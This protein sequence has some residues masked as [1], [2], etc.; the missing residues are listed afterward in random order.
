MNKVLSSFSITK[1]NYS[2]VKI[3]SF[4]L[5]LLFVITTR[6]IAQINYQLYN[7]FSKGPVGGGPGYE[8]MVQ[9]DNSFTRVNTLTELRT[10]LDNPS[11][12]KIFIPGN[13]YF[14]I[15]APIEITTDDL[16]IAS[17]RG[18]FYTTGRTSSGA[19]LKL[20]NASV[21]NNNLIF[22]VNA[23]N[24]RISGLRLTC[25]DVE[26]ISV[27]IQIR[28]K[29]G[30]EKMHLE[31][32][33]CELFNW[34]YAA[35]RIDGTLYT[36]DNLASGWV[37]H[38]HIHHNNRAGLGYGVVIN[39]KNVRSYILYNLF[40]ENR[41]SI[42]GNGRPNEMYTAAYNLTLKNSMNSEYDMHGYS[43]Y[44][45]K[46]C[47]ALADCDPYSSCN[48]AGARV[49]LLNNAVV[50]APYFFRIR[51]IPTE[52]A[53]VT[54]NFFNAPNSYMLWRTWSYTDELGSCELPVPNNKSIYLGKDQWSAYKL[55][56][57]DNNL[58]PHGRYIQYIS[59]SGRNSWQPLFFNAYQKGKIAFGD[60]NGDQVSDIFYSNGTSWQ[61]S[62]NGVTPWEK[63]NTSGY[64]K[65]QLAFGDFNGDS[66]TDVFTGNGSEWKVSWSG[67][68]GWERINTSGYKTHQLAFGDFNGDGTTDVFTG[69]GSEWKVS[70]SGTSGWERINTSGYKTHQLAFGDFNGDGITDVFAGKGSEWEVSWGG[71]SG[72]ERIN[73]T[74]YETHQLAFGDFNGDGTTDVFTGNGSE[75]KV[76]WS[77]TSSWERINTSIHKTGQLAFGDF[78]GDGVTDIIRESSF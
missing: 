36:I 20:R 3:V 76:S 75:W 24:V 72:W 67:T 32:D 62:W 15:D 9:Y 50:D 40:D 31:V 22:L 73:T 54:N 46:K 30:I 65:D 39:Y 41:H 28:A 59:W 7:D 17:D 47:D 66:K 58:N 74:G 42:A 23:N 43:D 5:L 71:T 35:V 16:L 78:N 21:E 44:N 27:G 69:N 8:A 77:G 38:N 11:I 45:K 52:G 70:W 61:V 33:N 37:H 12:K 18:Q 29:Y 56:V 64:Q 2:V 19:L 55:F 10:A 53:Y 26:L 68:S 1:S 60:F 57:W 48:T 14:E 6:G 49:I 4:S 51:G 25:E 63:L 34:G 13:L